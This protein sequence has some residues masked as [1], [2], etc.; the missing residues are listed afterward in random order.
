MPDRRPH[1]TRTAH[2][3]TPVDLG[4]YQNA[5]T[6]VFAAPSPLVT[7][8]VLLRGIPFTIG[9]IGS[10]T[11][12]VRIG[13]GGR[14]DPLRLIFDRPATSIAVAHLL[15]D[16]RVPAGGLPGLSVAEY[17]VRLETGETIGIPIRELF[18]IGALAVSPPDLVG[19]SAKAW[20]LAMTSLLAV[21][22][23]AT[24]L[25][26]RRSG[27]WAS[28]GARLSESADAPEDGYRLWV[29]RD[30]E[31]RRAVG[32]DITPIGA[33][34]IIAGV[35]VGDLDEDP[36]P[37]TG[38][39]PVVVTLMDPTES[40]VTDI[41]LSIDR[42]VATYTWPVLPGDPAAYLAE[43]VQGWGQPEDVAA[44]R[45]YAEV[46]ATPSATV[47]VRRDDTV[48]GTVRWGDVIAGGVAEDPGRVRI[49]W[50]DRT[51]QWVSTTVVDE[52]TGRP[53]P[54]RIHFRSTSGLPWQPHGHH[55]HINGDLPS[56][57]MDVGGDVR[58]GAV[59]YAVIDG[60]CEGWLPEGDVLVEVVRGF[61]YEPVRALVRIEPGQRELR[62]TIR[63]WAD[64]RRDGWVS[65]DTH[66]HFM[67][68]D[69][70]HLEAAAE[71]VHVVNLLQIQ[72]GHLFTNTEDFTGDPSIAKSGETIVHVGQE[73]R[74][75]V[76]GH[77]G[78]LGL[79]KPV[80]PWSSDGGPEAEIGGLDRDHAVA[81]GGRGSRARRVRDAAALQPEW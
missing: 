7:G 25:H 71:D 67:S 37:R 51:R 47:Q 5:G 57:H 10:E 28:A 55:N 62:V 8:D 35:T 29:W 1:D 49:E 48:L 6:S 66:V 4:Q 80:T 11:P 21:P 31:S 19:D 65:G 60:M 39:E 70:A 81:L 78:L 75:H 32:L 42:G 14:Q 41:E 77:L 34:F 40:S 22:G 23:A 27:P 38:R 33:P 63:R 15:V 74:Q 53:V 12:F 54:C 3:Y 50:V 61:E 44:G 13:P 30:R 59:S 26:P 76:L 2:G 58:L 46:A 36:I 64:L 69:G 45:L 43:T 52:A 68:V 79:R 72:W 24:G 20:Q 9:S 17:A 56:Q 73:N 18:E 16:S